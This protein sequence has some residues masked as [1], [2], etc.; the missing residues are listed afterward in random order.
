MKFY[1]VQVILGHLGGSNGLPTW[2]YVKARDIIKAIQKARNI[3][4][5]KHS[6]LPPKAFEITEE[7]YNLGIKQN[8]Y[9]ENIS[10]IFGE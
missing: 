7:E 1:K 5:V 9:R 6:Q 3:P 4:A 8:N 2:I 10:Q